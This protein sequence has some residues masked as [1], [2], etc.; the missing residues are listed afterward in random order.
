MSKIALITGDVDYQEFR[1]CIFLLDKIFDSDYICHIFRRKKV[2]EI[3]S[4][5]HQVYSM[6]EFSP[7]N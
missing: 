3:K 7:S 6:D 2:I 5:K 1:E 4:M